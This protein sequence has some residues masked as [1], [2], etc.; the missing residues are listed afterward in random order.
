[1]DPNGNHTAFV[2]NAHN[3]RTSMTDALGH[4]ST[5]A[6]DPNGNL[7]SHVD[8]DVNPATTYTYDALNRIVRRDAPLNQP[9][10]YSYAAVGNPTLTIDA[11]LDSTRNAYDALNR[12]T[13]VTDAR[14]KTFVYVYDGASN[15][16]SEQDEDLNPTRYEYDSRDRQVRGIGPLPDTTTTTY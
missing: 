5:D 4:T 15:R 9:T 14:G 6:Y 3:L 10:R 2:Y 7:V 1:T 11:R 16:V 12:L 8:F 13:T